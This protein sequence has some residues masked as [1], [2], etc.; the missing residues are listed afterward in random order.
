MH[1]EK[2]CLPGTVFAV[3]DIAKEGGH[4]FFKKVFYVSD[5]I[6]LSHL[7]EITGL[8]AMALQNWVKRKWVPN[9]NKK[10][11]SRE[12]L[13]RFLI[14]NMLRETLQISRI[15]YLLRYLN[16]TEPE[17]AVISEAD[18]Y[19]Y[20]CK[21][22]G[23]LIADGDPVIGALDR[24]IDDVLADYEEPVGGAKRRLVT[25]LRIMVSACCSAYVKARADAM[26]DALGA[27]PDRQ[28]ARH[29]KNRKGEITD[30]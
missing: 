19:D 24:V 8:D 10:Y 18:L 13:A 2:L 1:T 30:D 17:D 15:L 12:H 14:I 11:Y 28:T 7:R 22:F 23:A 25:T 26:L 27:P 9:P 16:G 6:M 20:V 4:A 5:H 3:G 29:G 21:C